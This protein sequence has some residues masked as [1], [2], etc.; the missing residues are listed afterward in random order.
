M[1]AVTVT[2]SNFDVEVLQAKGKVLVDFWAAW[3]G[4]CRMLGPIIDEIAAEGHENLKVCKLNVD[5][6]HATAGNYNVMSIPTMI[7][8]ENGKVVN[9][10]VGVRPKEEILAAAGV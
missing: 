1:S 5:E 7:V 4:P 6:N 9:K 8:F 2:D 10:L 3:C